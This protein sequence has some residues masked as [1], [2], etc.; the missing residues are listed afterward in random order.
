MGSR[1]WVGAYTDIPA[2]GIDTDLP[3]EGYAVLGDQI[4]FKMLKSDTGE[5]VNLKGD[6]P[7][8]SN[9][10]INIITYLDVVEDYNPTSFELSHVY[11][12]PFNPIT[13]IGFSVPNSVNVD[14]SI[15]D[16]QGR[17]VENLHSGILD[18]GEYNFAWTADGYASGVYFAKLSSSLGTDVQKLMLM[19]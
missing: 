11:P 12:N 19:K 13:E 7:L 2:M 3:T 6:V 15:Y 10:S 16:M 8:W 9:N 17:L 4:T 18:P 5:L 14:L 1:E